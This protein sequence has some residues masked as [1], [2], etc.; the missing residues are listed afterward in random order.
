MERVRDPGVGYGTW[1]GPEYGGGHGNPVRRINRHKRGSPN[2][3]VKVS[4]GNGSRSLPRARVVPVGRVGGSCPASSSAQS[5]LKL[6]QACQR[7]VQTSPVYPP[8]QLTRGAA[9]VRSPLRV[10]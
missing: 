10:K 6:G 4:A 9:Q 2:V 8:F 5:C 3:V 7:V 1:V